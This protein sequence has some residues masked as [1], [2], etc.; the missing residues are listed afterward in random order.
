MSQAGYR[1]VTIS[2]SSGREGNGPK[3]MSATTLY[4]PE[5]MLRTRHEYLHVP[6]HPNRK[7]SERTTLPL[8]L[9]ILSRGADTR[10]PFFDTSVA[11]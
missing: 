5:E 4:R 8:E 10:L 11:A 2:G 1:T 3:S 9:V 7:L 6:P